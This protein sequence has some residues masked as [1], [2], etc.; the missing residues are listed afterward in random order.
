[1]VPFP[2][3]E[4]FVR[5]DALIWA[6]IAPLHPRMQAEIPQRIATRPQESGGTGRALSRFARSGST[7][8]ARTC[9]CASCPFRALYERLFS[10]P[11]P[12]FIYLS[13]CAYPGIGARDCNGHD[14]RRWQRLWGS[15]S[16]LAE[17][18]DS[19]V[20]GSQRSISCPSV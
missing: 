10:C 14:H 7:R 1:M 15:R 17:L 8:R 11:A 18:C 4:I 12:F 5:T 9:S 19:C 2:P 13:T 20:A 16:S 6:W 3:N